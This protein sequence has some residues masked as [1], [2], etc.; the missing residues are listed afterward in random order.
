MVFSFELDMFAS[1]KQCNLIHLEHTA[2][3]DKLH[4]PH[5]ILLLADGGNNCHL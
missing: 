1:V 5:G 3:T 2:L 4:H